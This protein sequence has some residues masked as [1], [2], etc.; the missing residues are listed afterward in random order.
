MADSASEHKR[1]LLVVI[2]GLGSD[3]LRRALAAG[4]APNIQ[5]LIDHGARFDDAISPFPSL[6]PVCLASIITGTGPG[7][8]RIPSLGW[9]DRGK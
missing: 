6:T 2:D 5:A 3:P 9:Y 8:H 7:E 4:H 1:L